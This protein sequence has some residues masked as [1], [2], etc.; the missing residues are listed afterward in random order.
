MTDPS[1]M[2]ATITAAGT[3]FRLWAPHADS[4]HVIGD[5]NGWD[6]AAHPLSRDGEEWTGFVPGVGAGAQ[7]RFVLTHGDTSLERVDPYASLVTNSVGNGVLY[8]HAAFDW[9]GDAFVPP[10]LNEAIIYELH[11]GSFATSGSA[12]GNLWEAHGKLDHLAALAVTLIQIMPLAEFAGDYSWGYNPAHIFAVESAYGGPDALKSFVREAHQ[13]G[14]G[15][16]LDVVYNHFGPSDLN[17]WQFDGWSQDGLGGIYFYNDW[18]STTPWGDTRPD[19]GRDHVRAYIHDNALAWLRHY[20]LD[21]LRLDMTPYI[22]TVTGFSDDLPDGWS[23]LQELNRLVKDE[24]PRAITIAEDLHNFA[25]MTDPDGAGFSAQWDAQ[26]VHPIRAAVIAAN[27]ADRSVAAVAA[28]I[29]FSYGDPFARVIY[30]ESHDEVANG[31]ARVP[32][33]IDP[34]DP[35]GYVSQ[36]RSTL[37]AGFVFTTPGIPMLFQ[38]QEFLGDGWFRD[39]VPLDWP[40]DSEF[41]GIVRLYRDLIGLRRNLGGVTRGLLGGNVS[42][43]TADDTAKVIAYH[44]WMNGGPGD[45]V[46]V[47]ANLSDQHLFDYWIG[48]PNAG[49][50]VLRFNSDANDYSPAFTDVWTTNIH[51]ISPGRDGMAASGGMAL[52]PYT[53]LV[54]SQEPTPNP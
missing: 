5:W 38:G 32:Q 37:G 15:V 50:W 6:R 52:G 36:K 11:I 19:Y 16:V 53:M 29:T 8:D 45:D 7:Y 42:I 1:A 18:R 34:A 17:L 48:L 41:K 35:D 31:H 27:D 28:A 2:G 9:Q 54:F 12:V 43:I 26:F 51:A 25:A 39:D 13:R 33:E 30:T 23:L 14:I 10:L 3:G 44:R 20:H 46:V 40:Q 22:R 21:G 47:V 49:E 4:V 24:F